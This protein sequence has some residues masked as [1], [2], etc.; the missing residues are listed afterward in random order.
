MPD[1]AVAIPEASDDG[2]SYL[3]RLRPG[4]PFSTGAPVRASDVM[5]SIER[6]ASLDGA[7]G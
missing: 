4:S 2:L 7:D 1:L 6:A 3:F 5:R